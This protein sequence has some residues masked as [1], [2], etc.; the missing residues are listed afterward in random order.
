M[1]LEIFLVRIELSIDLIYE[2]AP[3]GADFVFNIHG[4]HTRCQVIR[5]ERLDISQPL[6]PLVFTDPVSLNRYLRLSAWSGPLKVSYHAVVDLHHHL[7][8]PELIAETPVSRLPTEVLSYIYPSR[9]C[10]SDLLGPLVMAEFGNLPQG[11]SR[12]VAIQDWVRRRVKFEG[13]T[14]TSAT[15]AIDTLNEGRGVCRDFAHLMIAL[16]RALNIPARFATASISA[17]TR[18]WAPPTSMPTWKSSWVGA[19][20]SSTRR[21]PP[22]PWVSCGSAPGVTRPTWP[23]P[24]SSARCSRSRR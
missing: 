21:A 20:T 2:V 12:V 10:Q 13:N 9:Y 14:T 22:S 1:A 6:L 15:S 8:A 17:R 24:P 5:S 11:Y 7:C 3:P 16:C 18:R 4:A 19:G 23:S